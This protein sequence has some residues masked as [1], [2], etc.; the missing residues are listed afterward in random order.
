MILHHV[1]LSLK[2]IDNITVEL[3]M[4]N[5]IFIAEDCKWQNYLTPSTSSCW[6]HSGIEANNNTQDEIKKIIN[7]DSLFYQELD[8]LF[9]AI[10]YIIK[11]KT[12]IFK[13]FI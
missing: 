12:K 7:V 10:L 9:K 1:S 4:S 11:F 3:N 13:P 6:G 2:I 5:H 8:D